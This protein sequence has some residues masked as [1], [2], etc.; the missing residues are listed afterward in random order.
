MANMFHENSAIKNLRDQLFGTD[1]AAVKIHIIN[2]KER[3]EI[4]ILES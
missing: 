4:N 2:K 1:K 3:K